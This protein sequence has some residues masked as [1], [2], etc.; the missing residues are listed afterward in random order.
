MKRFWSD[1]L[2]RLIFSLRGHVHQVSDWYCGDSIDLH[3]AKEL[4]W[5]L[6]E[7]LLCEVTS[8]NGVIELDELNNVALG[9]FPA[10]AKAAT[11]AVELLHCAEVSITNANNNNRARKLCKRNNLVDRIWHVVNGTI[12]QNQ[13]DWIH[14]TA[15]YRINKLA[16][17]T[18]QG[19]EVCRA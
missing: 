8:T 16:E 9:G 10:I 18:E 7:D 5:Y 6:F 15:D 3:I 1:H 12:C 11:I 17:L 14:V 13:Q 19:S 2:T 4:S